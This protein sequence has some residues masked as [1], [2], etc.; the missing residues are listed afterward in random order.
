MHFPGDPQKII[1]R[2]A[3][4]DTEL[5]TGGQERSMMTLQSDES[6][7]GLVRRGFVWHQ[8]LES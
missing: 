6:F 4:I 8:G 7:L 5:G 3:T 2:G 1:L